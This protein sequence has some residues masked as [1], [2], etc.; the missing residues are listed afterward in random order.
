MESRRDHNGIPEGRQG[1]PEGQ[2][3]LPEG[4]NTKH[5]RTQLIAERLR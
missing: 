3:E 2:R 4:Y 5:N 1:I